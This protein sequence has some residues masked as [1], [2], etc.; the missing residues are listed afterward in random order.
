MPHKDCRVEGRITDVFFHRFVIA[1]GDGSKILADLGPAGVDA[2]KIAP[3]LEIVATGEMKPSELKIHAIG[4]AGEPL[5]EI[6]HKKPPHKKPPHHG[7][8]HDDHP[9]A[10]ADPAAAKD[11]VARAGLAVLGEPRRKPKHFEVL[12]RR[13]DAFVECHVELDGHIRKE[14]PVGPDDPKWGDLIQNA[15]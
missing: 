10:P 12:A 15:A 5:V 11:A 9:H 13:G 3:G 8:G 1:R 14:K 6:A 4:R 7:P 2:F